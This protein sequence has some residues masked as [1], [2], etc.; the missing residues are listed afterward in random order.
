MDDPVV[1]VPTIRPFLLLVFRE[2]EGHK[3]GHSL[4]RKNLLNATFTIIDLMQ[5]S[6]PDNDLIYQYFY[7][8]S[9]L[10]R[11]WTLIFMILGL[12]LSKRIN[13]KTPNNSKCKT[14]CFFDWNISRILKGIR[15][16]LFWLFLKNNFRIISRRNAIGRIPVGKIQQNKAD[17]FTYNPFPS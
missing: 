8:S 12:Y 3:Q 6:W 5:T 10:K 11:I 13:Q 1:C 16:H 15:G 7:L 17:G 9:W 14:I 4:R 2:I